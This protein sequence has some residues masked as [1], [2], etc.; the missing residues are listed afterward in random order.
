MN[1]LK[2]FRLIFVSFI[3]YLIGDMFY[4]WDAFDYYG[5]FLEF[6]PAVALISVLWSLLALLTA[7][8]AWLVLSVL[9]KIFHL[10]K[11]E[12]HFED[13]LILTGLIV[14]LGL[15]SLYLKSSLWPFVRV[16]IQLKFGLVAGIAVIA[17]FAS[18]MMRNRAVWLLEMINERITPLVWLFGMIVVLSVPV[19]SYKAWS[20]LAEINNLAEPKASANGDVSRPNIIL[21]T[22]DAMT[23][24]DMSVYGYDRETTPFISKWAESATVFLKLQAASNYTAP[25]VATLMTGKRVWVHR[26]FQS[27]G[28][29][30]NK[31]KTENIPLLLKNDG[32]VNMAFVANDVAS[33][34]ELGISESFIAAPPSYDLMTPSSVIGYSFRFLQK[35]FGNIQ[36]FDWIL[37]EDFILQKLAPDNYFKYPIKNQFP[38]RKVTERFIAEVQRY[39][40]GPYFAWLHLY[41]P[42][43][44]YL[45]PD[46]YA[47]IFNSSS[48]YTTA[49]SQDGLVRPR[50]FSEDQQADADILRARYDEFIR[51]CD[52]E[53]KTFIKQLEESDDMKN[54][55]IILSADHGE[56][57]E[58]GYF[59]HGG[60]FLFEQMTSI[61][62]IIKLPGHE[63]GQIVHDLVD[64]A[65]VPATILDI[66]GIPVPSWVEGRSLLPYM[67]GDKPAPTPVF[68]MD[69]IEVPVEEKIETG[70]VAVWEGNYKLIHYLKKNESVLFNLK[71]DPGELNDIYSEEEKIGRHLLGLIQDN[72][73]KVNNRFSGKESY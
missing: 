63:E 67:R 9:K 65:D 57:F 19:I 61:P 20:N 29:K 72:L 59:S 66:A 26:R 69:L 32:Y 39:R 51:Y 18:I 44:P 28:G 50:Y 47:N 71:E 49:K 73:V 27:N 30:P 46:N 6:I 16:S 62:L 24:R 52:N 15:I 70:T 21:I 60:P 3:L 42:H 2:V 1:F 25:T 23:A 5:S 4:R 53:F 34:Q 17:L 35:Y 41:P 48:K 14:L 22:F 36:E 37:L 13:L 55:V 45:A 12:V 64:Q 38:I 40:K 33:V 54:T 7:I 58:H 31:G 8:F 56:S 10:L 11:L 68:S 43:L